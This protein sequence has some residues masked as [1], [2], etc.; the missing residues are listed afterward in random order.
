MVHRAQKPDHVQ[1]LVILVSSNTTCIGPEDMR[2]PREE[3]LL[4]D[5]ANPPV[6][7]SRK[8]SSKGCKRRGLWNGWRQG[9]HCLD[10]NDAM[11][12]VDGIPRCAN[13]KGYIGGPALEEG[14]VDVSLEL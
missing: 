13:S 12:A 2:D 6:K 7:R 14:V 4:S 5:S 11:E 10:E 9:T 8:N 1:A 3:S